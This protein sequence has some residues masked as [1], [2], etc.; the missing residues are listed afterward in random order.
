MSGPKPIQE[1]QK[2]RSFGGDPVRQM[3]LNAFLSPLFTL[4]P[5][6]LALVARHLTLGEPLVWAAERSLPSDSW[7][8]CFLFYQAGTR[9]RTETEFSRVACWFGGGLVGSSL[10]TSAVAVFLGR[11]DEI[12]THVFVEALFGVIVLAVVHSLWRSQRGR[13]AL[14]ADPDRN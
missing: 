7:I 14:Q 1:G 10:A 2:L 13:D 3:R 6:G 9:C 12:L 5:K 4:A 8:L 11:T